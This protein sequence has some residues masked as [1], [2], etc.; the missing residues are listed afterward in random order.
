M[1]SPFLIPSAIIIGAL[2]GSITLVVGASLTNQSTW[3]VLTAVGTIGAVVW[4]VWHQGIL[5]LINRP[6]LEIEP[7][8]YSRQYLRHARIISSGKEDLEGHDEQRCY[9]DIQIKNKGRTIAR[10]CQPLLTAMG[11]VDDS[12]R[13]QKQD[14]WA[15]IG[16]DW[17]LDEAARQATGQPTEE[18]DIVRERPY[19]FSLGYMSTK[20]PHY[21]RFSTYLIPTGQPDKVCPY[22]NCFEVTVF[23]EN[24]KPVKKYFHLRYDNGWFRDIE[25]IKQAM[26]VFTADYPPW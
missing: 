10:N 12:G 14:N 7:P 3:I 2:V 16:L 13:W 5:T 20:E 1:K 4:A 15:P 6:I 11:A 25:K 17:I 9:L 8:D 22:K 21:F 19:V 26:R 24:A 18:K 23:A